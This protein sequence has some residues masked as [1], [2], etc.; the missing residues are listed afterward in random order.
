MTNQ[1]NLLHL[2]FLYIQ[3]QHNHNTFLDQ[4]DFFLIQEDFFQSLL[5]LMQKDSFCFL[6]HKYF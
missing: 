2:L 1:V 6:F 3:Y 5:F 4:K